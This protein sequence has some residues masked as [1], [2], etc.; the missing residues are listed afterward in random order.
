M[1]YL[2]LFLKLLF[3][4]P[5]IR[6]TASGTDSQIS[7]NKLDNSASTST[8]SVSLPAVG[9]YKLARY[10]GL[11]ESLAI[12]MQQILWDGQGYWVIIGSKWDF[13]RIADLPKVDSISLELQNLISWYSC[14]TIFIVE[15]D[16]LTSERQT[17]SAKPLNICCMARRFLAMPSQFQ[18]QSLNE[19]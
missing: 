9:I 2:G 1:V 8:K 17:M 10:I 19:R 7:E 5:P 14:K 6:I 3:K 15:S 11:V 4:S 13:H 18:K 16:P 12:L